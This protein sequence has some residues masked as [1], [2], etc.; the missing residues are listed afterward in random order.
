MATTA[1]YLN[2]LIIQKNAL[3]D[4]LVTKGI[5]ATHN[6]TLETLVPKVLDINKGADYIRS[7]LMCEFNDF[8]AS[9]KQSSISNL[10]LSFT[11]YTFE[12]CFKS[13]AIQ[14]YCAVLVE[15]YNNING[16]VYMIS[17]RFD[18]YSNPKDANYFEI[19]VN[20]TKILSEFI[21]SDNIVK[22]GIN[23]LYTLSF[24]VSG[25]NAVLYAN[26]EKVR[27]F[28]GVP[29]LTT[30]NN[31]YNLYSNGTDRVHNGT[32]YAVRFYNKTL[33]NEEIIRNYN[34]DVE[35]FNTV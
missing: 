29:T 14:K 5:D 9:T 26:G 6:E 15:T 25:T 32:I 22:F 21:D 12:F 33:S 17:F 16:T 3:A 8:S 1:D 30:I 27:E 7:N 10:G 2:K 23:I 13:Y 19:I 11:D 35:I 28:T 24:V 34:K 31:I 18:S 4:N 20:N